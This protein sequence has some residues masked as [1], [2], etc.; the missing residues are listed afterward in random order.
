MRA[1]DQKL[2][3]VFVVV[4]LLWSHSVHGLEGLNVTEM[5]DEAEGYG[6]GANRRPLMVGLSLIYGAAAKGA[7]L[8]LKFKTAKCFFIFFPF[9]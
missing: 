7:G 1:K 2:I 5:I 9:Y 4:E 3:W 8:L 6:Y